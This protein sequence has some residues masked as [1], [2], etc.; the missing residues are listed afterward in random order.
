M[1]RNAGFSLIEL[2]VAITLGLLLV[3]G[4][5]QVFVSSKQ[6]YRVQDSVGRL[7]ENARFASGYLGQYI[8]QAD[9]WSGVKPDRITTASAVYG[10]PGGCKDGWIVDVANGLVGYTGDTSG[11]ALSYPAGLPSNCLNTSGSGGS[12]AN[13]VA[14]SDV[15]VVR[16]VDPGTYTAIASATCTAGASA[17]STYVVNGK[18][19][20]RTQVGK[21]A[22]LFNIASSE[23]PAAIAAIPGDAA[24]GVLNFQYR[25]VGFYLLDADNGQGS[26]P[27]LYLL[28]LQGDALTPQPLVDGIEMMKFEYGVDTDGDGRV[29]SYLTAS[30]ITAPNWKRV[31]TVRASLIVRG[32]ALDNYVDN[33]SYTMTGAGYV[34]TPPVSVRRFQRR[35]VVREI[36]VRNR[37]R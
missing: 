37:V 11:T 33:Q 23:C 26:T 21:R 6:A 27:T 4:V 19:Y 13:Y 29:D 5:A 18:Y 25:A 24:D 36:Q 12:A 9:L 35:L 31:I 2:M 8:R 28:T 3:A 7:Q 30:A 32:D 20:L 14:G 15:L 1:N 17:G 16:Y 22:Q 34:Y 10:G